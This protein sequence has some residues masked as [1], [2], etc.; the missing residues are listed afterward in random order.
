MSLRER[1]LTNERQ[2]HQPRRKPIE[3]N[4]FVILRG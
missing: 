3:S 1:I 2:N 4:S